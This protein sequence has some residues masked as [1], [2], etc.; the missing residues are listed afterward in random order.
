[1]AHLRLT[2]SFTFKGSSPSPDTAQGSFQEEAAEPGQQQQHPQQ[3]TYSSLVPSPPLRMPT[4][5]PQGADPGQL[6]AI[7]TGMRSSTGTEVG[8]WGSGGVED[9][10]PEA[11]A[12]AV[13]TNR[14]AGA[15][16][17]VAASIGA[18]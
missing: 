8:G 17:R 4:W 13:P 10:A 16:G 7:A 11:V 9:A 18:A 2:D 14:W 5:P 6:A 3:T 15:A 12:F 1:M